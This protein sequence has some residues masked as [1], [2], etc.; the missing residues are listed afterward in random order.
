LSTTK[1]EKI[2]PFSIVTP[3][4]PVE[5]PKIK[6]AKWQKALQDAYMFRYG[7]AQKIGK[8]LCYVVKSL[9]S[10]KVLAINDAMQPIL[11]TEKSVIT[12]C[13]FLTTSSIDGLADSKLVS[14]E[15]YQK[16]IDSVL[17]DFFE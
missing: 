16:V 2:N 10:G 4:A 15:E 17:G 1:F 13:G 7:H 3:N 11:I 9:D 14:E 5:D 8:T 12:P 6:L